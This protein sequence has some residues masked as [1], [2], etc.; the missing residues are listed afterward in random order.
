M[1]CI[2]IF[3][4]ERVPGRGI[5]FEPARFFACDVPVAAPFPI[6]LP[7]FEDFDRRLVSRQA[8]PAITRGTVQ[9]IDRGGGRG[10]TQRRVEQGHGRSE[11]WPHQVALRAYRC[12]D[13]NYLTIHFFCDAEGLLLCVARHSCH[14]TTQRRPSSASRSATTRRPRTPARP[15]GNQHSRRSPP[16]YGWSQSSAPIRDLGLLWLR[17]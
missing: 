16:A 13:Q 2:S 7:P 9:R 4:I 10:L 3:A 14:D 5:Q 11:Q 12:L 8:L 15:R 17:R 1:S 6:G